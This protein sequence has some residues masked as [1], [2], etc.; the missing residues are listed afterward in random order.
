L[1][2]EGFRNLIYVHG[3]NLFKH[4]FAVKETNCCLIA[5]RENAIE[6]GISSIIFHR[7][8]LE[9]Y[10]R[11]C[12]CFLYSLRP[13]CVDKGPRIVRLMT[14]ASKK[15]DVGPMASV[16]GVLADLAVE[17]MTSYGAKVAVVENGGEVSA[18]SNRP[19]DVILLAGN[20]KLSGRLGF[21]LEEFPS[22]VATS[23]GVFGHALSFGEAEAVTIFSGN[24]GLAD[25]AATATC[26]IV[27]GADCRKAVRNG[28]ST[29]LSIKNVRGV[30][31]IYKGVAGFGGKVP[32]VTRIVK[33]EEHTQF[34]N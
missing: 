34:Q 7:R 21:R 32:N 30:F 4:T 18:M 19:I 11:N 23:S 10:I 31:I 12:P 15:A 6:E 9:E 14:S 13:V 25:A 1:S 33:E 2:K 20:H 28:I 26:N 3:K 16:A 29:A 17:A 24:A 5:D 22:G 8:R 27:K